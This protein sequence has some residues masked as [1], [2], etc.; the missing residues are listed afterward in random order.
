MNTAE[1]MGSAVAM[2]PVISRASCV[3]QAPPL[4]PTWRHRSHDRY[5]IAIS[6]YEKLATGLKQTRKMLTV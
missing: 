6:R 1:M 5:A 4:F 3:T 2:E